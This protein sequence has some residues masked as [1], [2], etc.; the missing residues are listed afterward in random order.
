MKILELQLRAFGP[1]TDRT[2][3]LRP[4]NEGLYVIY[5]PNE[6]GKSTALVAVHD[7]LYGIHPQTPYGFLHDYQELRIGGRL[8]HSDGRELLFTRRKGSRDTIL[9]ADGRPLDDRVLLPYLGGITGEQFLRVFGIDNERMVV[10]ARNILAGRGDVGES[11]FAASLGANVRGVLDELEAAANELFLKGGRKPKINE[12]ISR[13]EEAKREVRQAS[14]SAREWSELVEAI[15]QTHTDRT[16]VA[17]ELQEARSEYTR[18]DRVQRA[19]ARIADR[20]ECLNKLGDIGEVV[21]LPGDFGERHRK[22]MDTLRHNEQQRQRAEGEI[23]RLGEQIAAL[24]APDELLAQGETITSL[25]QDLGKYQQ[26]GSDRPDLHA[27][28]QSLRN[29]AREILRELR[30]DL[31]VGRAETLRLPQDE[32]ARIERLGNAYERVTG[33]ADRTRKELDE[34]EADLSP[35]REECAGLPPARDAGELRRTVNRVRGRGEL[36]KQRDEL[37]RQLTPDSE[38]AAVEL[39]RLP[40]WTKTLERLE[41][42]PVPLVETIERFDDEFQRIGAE[43][44]R[45]REQM[46]TVSKRPFAAAGTRK[47]RRWTLVVLYGAGGASGLLAL[48][49]LA[50]SV[51]TGNVAVLF[52]ALATG[53]LAFFVMR[54]ASSQRRL[55]ALRQRLRHKEDE[56]GAAQA[57]WQSEWDP[58]ATVPST[59]R[60]MRSWLAQRNALV[61]RAERIRRLRGDLEAKKQ[62]IQDCRRELD[63]AL[64]D[65]G[66]ELAGEE[67]SLVGLLER[68]E[69]LLAQIDEELRK[70]EGM[71]NDIDR[72]EL[73]LRAAREEHRQAQDRL[74]EWREEWAQ[75]LQPLGLSGDALPDEAMGFR[76]RL[77]EM[78]AALHDAVQLQT[79]IEQIDASR[80]EFEGRVEA[81]RHLVADLADRLPDYVASELRARLATATKNA[82]TQKARKEQLEQQEMAR[83]AAEEGIRQGQE[84]L[85]EL[86]RIAECSD[87][88]NLEATEQRNREY[89]RYREQLESLDDSLRLIGQGTSVEELVE[90]AAEVDPDALPGQ[91][92]ELETRVKDLEQRL[93]DLD[94]Q[95]G[96]RRQHQREMDGSDMAA[97]AAE[98]AQGVLAELRVHVDRYVRL[99]LAERILRREIERYRAEHQ[100]PLLGRAGDLFQRLTLGSFAGLKT[101]Y[102]PNDEPVLKGLRPAGEALGVEAMS[103][104]T[105]D[106]LYVA[107]RL[108]SLEQYLSTNEPIPFIVDDILIR[109]DD[110]RSRATL[111]VLAEL[112]RQTQVL[113]FTHHA[114][115]A[116]LA[117]RLR[118]GGGL[119]VHDLAA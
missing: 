5:G 41:Q 74:T 110:E 77:D 56:L 26:A 64:R 8:R 80:A 72:L 21:E 39:A 101:D 99:R 19:L 12:A 114:R 118:G 82:E 4:G 65:L 55:A 84:E 111:E 62:I 98:R 51:A 17:E 81:L 22:A 113:F 94:Q 38:Q 47:P 59:P 27:K 75:A 112:S 48:T 96:E 63:A 6:A 7:L 71:E 76:N 117:K 106:Q 90:Q 18:L 115:L 32:R 60:E 87:A 79:R 95:I 10:G 109:F 2:L 50:M 46:G 67:E 42:A 58:V 91:I 89:L 31:D 29:T 23:T 108:A 69:D 24:E 105:R 57:R 15:E 86:C 68:C 44:D 20:K 97:E 33:D 78:F 92:H 45:V 104:G 103:D 28:L 107:L 119:F 25:H 14:L 53:A 37:Q 102:G 54:R 100:G 11:L 16:K 40:N 36:E 3:D 30:P 70:R 43:V 13:H 61:Q 66:E 9:D 85:E 35:T 93:S 52:G 88:N 34:F 73:N 116:E 83:R 1:F 49:A